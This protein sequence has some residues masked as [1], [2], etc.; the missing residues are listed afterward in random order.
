VLATTDRL[1]PEAPAAVAA[2]RQLTG[3]TPLPLTG[4]N[5]ATADRLQPIVSDSQQGAVKPCAAVRF[6]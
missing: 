6:A 3:A 2:A 4:D 1:R 5:Q